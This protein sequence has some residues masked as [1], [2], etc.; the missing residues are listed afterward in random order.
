M[1][2]R[3]NTK[4]HPP[5]AIKYISWVACSSTLEHGF[6]GIHVVVFFMK[7]ITK[8]A[9]AMPTDVFGRGHA[10]VGDLEL[11]NRHAR[12]ARKQ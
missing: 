12:G 9:G 11:L 8:T 2:F 7:R 4:I 5:S 3:V 6:P 1:S 10:I